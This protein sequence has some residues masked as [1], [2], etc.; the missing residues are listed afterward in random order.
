MDLVLV[1]L[2]TT[3]SYFTL[4]L[5]LTNRRL[6][7]TIIHHDD[8]DDDADKEDTLAKEFRKSRSSRILDSCSKDR[9]LSSRPESLLA[10]VSP[11]ENIQHTAAIFLGGFLLKTAEY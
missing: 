2:D 3:Y 8:A 6:L 5:L 1:V 9:R 11:V 10:E 4:L 7:G